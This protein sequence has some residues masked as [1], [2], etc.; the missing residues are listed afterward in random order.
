MHLDL[1]LGFGISG[2]GGGGQF[3]HDQAAR[4]AATL[5]RPAVVQGERRTSE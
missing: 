5:V 3:W 1:R 4:S 2:K